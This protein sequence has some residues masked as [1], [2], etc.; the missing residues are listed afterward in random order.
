MAPVRGTLRRLSLDAGGLALTL[1]AGS[2]VVAPAASAL[3]EITWPAARGALHVSRGVGFLL[4]FVALD[5]L[6]YW[7]HRLFHG[8]L[9]YRFHHTHHTLE[10]MNGLGAFRRSLWECLVSPVFWVCGLVACVAAQPSFVFLGVSTGLVLDVWRHSSLRTRASGP[11]SGL[12][13]RALVTPEDH[14][15]HHFEPPVPGNFGSNLKV[16]DVLHG[17]YVR[18][19]EEPAPIGAP[20]R[21][22][23]LRL[24]LGV[25]RPGIGTRA[26]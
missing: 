16:W 4:G 8:R 10:R 2:L 21:D 19:G 5:Y 3:L 7:T 15:I 25:P 20:S 24:L 23:V 26:S 13:R 17:T 9:L 1:A 14:A 11:L 12:L 6:Q 22:G 18:P